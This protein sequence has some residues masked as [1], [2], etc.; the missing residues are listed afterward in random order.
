[1]Q[2]HKWE[3]AWEEKKFS[4]E[5]LVPSILVSK[6]E[7]QLHKGDCILDVGCGNGRNSIYLAQKGMYVDCFDVTDL[8]WLKNLTP[9]IRSQIHFTKAT[10][11]E[12]PY[13][14][15][16]YSAIIVARVIQYLSPVELD[17]LISKIALALKKDGFLLLSFNTRGG[18]FNKKEIDVPVYSHSVE[19]VETSL[20][21]IFKN[22]VIIEGSK[23]SKHVNYVDDIL[24]FDI[25]ASDVI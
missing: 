12:Y 24:T 17:F 16:H 13:K 5:T 22:V 10:I 11:A 3:K 18:I 2:K 20:R 6:Y 21:K 25:Y 4:I 23:K 1:M 7:Y 9:D 15:L 19:Y 8:Q 14:K